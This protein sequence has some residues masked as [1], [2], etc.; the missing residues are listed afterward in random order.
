MELS[1]RVQA[2]KP[3]P[4]LAVT[5]LAAH[6]KS[7]GKD[8]IG[9]GAG[10]PDFDTPQH[11]KDAAIRAIN[12]GFTKYTEVDGI[13]SL[14]QA[15]IDK[16]KRDNGLDYGLKQVI[17]SCGGKQSFF[18]LVQAVINPGDEVIIPA[19]YWVS[20]PD[21]VVLADGVP[22]FIE[23]GIEQR[24][25]ITPQQ[26][27]AAI[28]PKTK[29]VVI[30]SPSNPTGAVYSFDELAALGK[31]L[32]DHPRI[33][34]ASDDMYEHIM[35][36]DEKFVNILNA[37]P[38]LYPRTMVL[39]GVSKSYSMTGWRIGY[40]AGPAPIV[41]AMSKV[42]SQSTSNP[43]SISQVAAEAALNGDQSC[44]QP[45]LAAFRERHRF[46]VDTLN[47]IP[48]IQCL[49]AGGAFYA[50]AD[51]RGAISTLH[52]QGAIKE[53]TDVALSGFLLEKAEVAVVPG[54]AFGAEGYM[55][56]SFA[57]SM[58]NLEKAL[59]RIHSALS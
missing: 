14:K 9:L 31:I 41:A 20:Y 42:Q 35:L 32:R 54:S 26:L 56:L 4:T 46:V 50:F 29:M 21:I 40:A 22:V 53:A 43:T 37:C 11:I 44:I 24:F 47:E 10:E 52:E 33:L 28:T 18:N 1:K 51:A 34:I 7:Q 59:A 17:V 58:G 2:I 15:V 12:S 3:S 39:N 23:A 36:G 49:P 57:T 27:A 45:M 5:A 8:I 6:L 55:R 30:N 38:D 25:K 19:P 48:G 13:P 16:L